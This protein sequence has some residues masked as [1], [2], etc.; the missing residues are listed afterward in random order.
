M[1]EQYNLILPVYYYCSLFVNTS[2]SSVLS[3]AT[4]N[5]IASAVLSP[6]ALGEP[7]ALLY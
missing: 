5:G 7:F 3:S 1:S 4:N 6:S 2:H